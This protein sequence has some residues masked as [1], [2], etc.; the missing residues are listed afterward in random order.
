MVLCLAFTFTLS[1]AFADETLTVTQLPA[2]EPGMTLGHLTA[3]ED[4]I[5]GTA[6]MPV[7]GDL[8]IT[9]ISYDDLP[10][11]QE[12]LLSD[13]V[14]PS[15]L[16]LDEVKDALKNSALTARSEVVQYKTGNAAVQVRLYVDSTIKLEGFE[17]FRSLYKDTGYGTTPFFTTSNSSYINTKVQIGRK[18]FYKFRGYVT[19]DGVKYYTDYSKKAYRIVRGIP[20]T[21]YHTPKPLYVNELTPDPRKDTPELPIVGGFTPVEDGTITA[22]LQAKF[23]AALE[24]LDG[25]SYEAVKLVATQV[26]AGTN[27]KFLAN[28]KVVVPGAKATQ[29]YVIV[30]E[31][32][33]GNCSLL[34][35]EDVEAQVV[36]GLTQ[37]NDL[38]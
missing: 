2:S 14:D 12:I 17:I 22:E 29:K 9:P 25:V 33:Q 13:V 35:V 18:Y 32:L 1:G 5:S 34:E 30:Y 20:N 26:V 36:D 37:A 11:G 15:T 19:V 27:Y 10:Y 4:G 24:G 31:D 28:A 16:T 21:M 38:R 6:I 8:D 7:L 23:D 3:T